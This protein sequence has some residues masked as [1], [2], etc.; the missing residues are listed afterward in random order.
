MAG[1]SGTPFS[2]N[3]GGIL[4]SETSRAYWDKVGKQLREER[5]RLEKE[6]KQMFGKSK[7]KAAK[8]LSKLNKGNKAPLG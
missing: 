5:K 1:T 3:N 7:N 6:M 8:D 4:P 2:S